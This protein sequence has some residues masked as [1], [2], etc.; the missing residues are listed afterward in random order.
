MLGPSAEVPMA[1]VREC[2]AANVFGLLEL[3]QAGAC[4]YARMLVVFV[5][6]CICVRGQGGMCHVARGNKTASGST[7]C[8]PL[9]YTTHVCVCVCHI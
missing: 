5:R 9:T 7:C 6:V 8:S 2:F 4:V 1:S 3:C